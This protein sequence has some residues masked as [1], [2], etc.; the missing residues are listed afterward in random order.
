M[1]SIY[2]RKLRN[3][4]YG[5]YLWVKYYVNGRPIYEST[6]ATTKR[7]A[8]RFLALREGERRRGPLFPPDL[9]VSCTMS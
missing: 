9:T 5:K 4:E 2:R 3:G 1:G 7:E 8:E 6:K